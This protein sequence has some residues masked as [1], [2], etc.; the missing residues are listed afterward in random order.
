MQLFVKC[1][2]V[3]STGAYCN[4]PIALEVN[5]TDTVG[6]VKTMIQ[7]RGGLKKE[8][9]QLTF[10]GESLEDRRT[11][12]SYNIIASHF[13]LEDASNFITVKI[14]STSMS[15]LPDKIIL[16]EMH[17]DRKETVGD[18]KAKIQER[19]GIPMHQH[20]LDTLDLPARDNTPLS[21]LKIRSGARINLFV[22]VAPAAA[23]KGSM[24]IFVKTLTGKNITLRVDPI[25]TVFHIKCLLQSEGSPPVKQRLIFAR[26]DLENDRKLIDYNI[27]HKSTLYLKYH[28]GMQLFVKILN[29]K[30]VPLNVEFSESIENVKLKIEN[31]KGIPP[32]LQRLTFAGKQ[33]EDGRTLSDYNIQKE[34]T[35][36]LVVQLVAVKTSSEEFT[37]PTIEDCTVRDLKYSLWAAKQIPPECQ[38]ILC[39]ARVLDL[40]EPISPH[41]V[42]H[43]Q[44]QQDPV[45]SVFVADRKS[46]IISIAVTAQTTVDN[47]RAM[48]IWK[49]QIRS[50][51]SICLSD[52]LM[53]F[54][55]M[56]LDDGNNVKD[57]NIQAGIL[58][59]TMN[60]IEGFIC[61]VHFAD[62]RVCIKISRTGSFLSLKAR[63]QAEVP[64]IPSPC[65][66]QLTI[67]DSPMEDSQT[68]DGCG[69]NEFKPNVTLSVQPPPRM[70]VRNSTGIVIQV[71]IYSEKEVIS[72]KSLI[73]DTE[74]SF[75][76]ISKQQ[77]Y[78]RGK[79]LDDMHT[80]SSYNLPRDQ[81]LQLCVSQCIH[82]PLQ[83]EV[84]PQGKQILWPQYG[85]EVNVPPGVI[86]DGHALLRMYDGLS[87]TCFKYPHE[88]IPHSNVYELIISSRGEDPR[89]VTVTLSN[90][91][92]HSNLCLMAA[93]LNPYKWSADQ[94]TPLFSFSK[95]E[96]MEMEAQLSNGRV[97]VPLKSSGV[98][99]FVAGTGNQPL[100]EHTRLDLS[101]SSPPSFVKQGTPT[102]QHERHLIPKPR[103]SPPPQ[104]ATPPSP[105]VYRAAGQYSPVIFAEPVYLPHPP[106]HQDSSPVYLPPPQ[107]TPTAQHERHLIPQQRRSPPPQQG[108]P[109][110][111]I[112]YQVAGPILSQL[113]EPAYSP[114]APHYQEFSP[115][116][117]TMLFCTRQLNDIIAQDPQRTCDEMIAAGLI[118]SV[119][120]R[121]FIRHPTHTDR[122]KATKLVDFMTDKVKTS[123]SDFDKF[124]AI[125]KKL[126]WT[127]H[128]VGIL[129]T[130]LADKR[131]QQ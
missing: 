91:K 115:E 44:I 106:Y 126:S 60:C 131:T 22:P 74:S 19:E 114:H 50:N 69:V 78:Y 71:S 124:M 101:M 23:N 29:H 59:N 117:T 47:I 81:S 38:T 9:Q 18:L 12:D 118:Q 129:L 42:V 102:S 127:E 103:R 84:G 55:G 125:L 24:T 61:N 96:G 79:A 108:T 97:E 109:P 43:L 26:K 130:T 93:S 94:L 1:P 4:G 100:S 70:F 86:S 90:F 111:P 80:I 58:V 116:Y 8:V 49:T 113:P 39:N 83:E 56:Q 82:E 46:E 54:N 99:L 2:L 107:G 14:I 121:E 11:L 16:L 63:L 34:N 89:G 68:M 5:S 87:A 13:L 85:V 31:K 122:A 33:L 30:T 76:E 17:K 7:E 10:L 37:V 40:D 92:P 28:G 20:Q 62:K 128:I 25:N 119:H 45:F 98:Y 52:Y 65:L 51:V 35:I 73:Q 57:Y 21:Y 95:V 123:P 72:L 110:S 77:L 3:S 64:E 112:V 105:I 67:N 32:H 66:Q 75:P 48:L 27:K 53:F 104:R 36:H 15:P 41:Y 120:I 6:K 88:Y